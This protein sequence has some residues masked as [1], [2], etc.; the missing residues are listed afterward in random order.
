MTGVR[1]VCDSNFK[2][3]KDVDKS[4]S[5]VLKMFSE[6]FQKKT[7]PLN[8][9]SDMECV[10][11]YNNLTPDQVRLMKK[12]LNQNKSLINFKEIILSKTGVSSRYKSKNKS[13]LNSS[14]SRRSKGTSLTSGSSLTDGS[15]STSKS[16]LSNRTTLDK[17]CADS[18]PI[19]SQKD[20]KLKRISLIAQK[21]HELA[22]EV[23]NLS[24]KK[25]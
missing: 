1:I 9:D 8:K 22:I 4:V 25:K 6:H 2:E 7:T 23:Q 14:R 12:I 13:K 11:V 19:F 17:S 21:L 18:I 15:S 16:S 10:Y 24:I 3:T 5:K 20:T